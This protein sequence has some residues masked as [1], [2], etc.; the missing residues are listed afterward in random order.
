MGFPLN[1]PL[2]FPPGVIWHS[3]RWRNALSV[4]HYGTKDESSA[5]LCG[6]DIKHMFCLM[7]DHLAVIR[8]L[9][10]YIPELAM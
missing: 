7:D 1:Y 9:S 2:I 8:G 6:T 3:L 10:V 4:P 5:R